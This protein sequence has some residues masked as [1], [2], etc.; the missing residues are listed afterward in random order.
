MFTW[1]GRYVRDWLDTST[2]HSLGVIK[3]EESE[4]GDV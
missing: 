4:R 2:Q 1:S 3:G